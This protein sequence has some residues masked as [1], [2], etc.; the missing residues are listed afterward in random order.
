MPPRA[1]HNRAEFCNIVAEGEAAA[2][3]PQGFRPGAREE[4][5]AAALLADLADERP[6]V[7][8]LAE[9]VFGFEEA[10]IRRLPRH[11]LHGV[12]FYDD[13]GTRE[14]LIVSPSLWR[15]HS[16]ELR[17]YR[18]TA[19]PSLPPAQASFRRLERIS[20][21]RGFCSTESLFISASV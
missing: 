18:Q 14:S 4:E 7:A 19:A 10:V 21:I 5:R 6:E 11:G 3:L 13:W 12:A 9:R 8:V 20:L 16:R 1:Y 2:R 17:R 15:R